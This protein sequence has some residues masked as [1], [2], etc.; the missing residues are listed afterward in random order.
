MY[1]WNYFCF[2]HTLTN[3]FEIISNSFCYTCTIYLRLPV[4]QTVLSPKI[5]TFAIVS[6]TLFYVIEAM[7]VIIQ[8]LIPYIFSTS[9]WTLQTCNNAYCKNGNRAHTL[10][11][12]QSSNTFKARNICRHIRLSLN[13][14]WLVSVLHFIFSFVKIYE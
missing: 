9:F 10:K 13:N 14:K 4:F 2:C 6:W 5:I 12:N 7:S 3:I 1:T 8:N 11:I